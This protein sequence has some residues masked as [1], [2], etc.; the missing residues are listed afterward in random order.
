MKLLDTNGGNTKLRKNN[1]DIKIRV[2]GLSLYPNDTICPFRNVA[3]CAKPCLVSSGRGGFDNVKNGRQ[4]KTDFY[5]RDRKGFIAQ[6]KKELANFEKLCFKNGVVPYIRLNVIS[7]IQWELETNGAIP[8]SFPNINFFDYTK[9][10]KRLDR[11]PSNYQ[12]MFSYS[13]APQYQE[14]VKKALKTNV[15]ISVVF[16]GDMPSTFM[17][18]RVVNGDNSDIENLKHK[19][20]IIGLKY[21]NAKGQGIDPLDHVFIVD[22]TQQPLNVQGVA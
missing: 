2:G 11:T 8:Q 22:T 20:C 13:N 4:A 18:K 1:K 6:L 12:L 19:G 15:P 14:S 3:Q 21:K 10:A 7:D 5:L 17:G 16:F 9:V